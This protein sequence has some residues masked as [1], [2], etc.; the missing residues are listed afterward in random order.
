MTQ[1]AFHFGAPDRMRY[2]CRLLRKIAASGARAVVCGE[3][4]TLAAVESGLW[5]VA[6]TDF[7]PHAMEGAVGS[8]VRRSPIVLVSDPLPAAP[9]TVLVN[10]LAQMPAHYTSYARVIEVVSAEGAD[11][12]SARAK[13]RQYTAA[14]HSIVRHDLKLK[15][16][17]A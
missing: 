15:E 14:G 9:D 1:V 4:E 6:P 11:R 7:V 16:G 5:A 3:P 10:L 12:D 17:A 2:T 8:Q 13:W